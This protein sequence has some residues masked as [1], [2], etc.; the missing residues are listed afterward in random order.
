MP[1]REANGDSTPG[2]ALERMPSL[3][4]RNRLFGKHSQELLER[5]YDIFE[6]LHKA[7]LKIQTKKCKLFR[8]ETEF[9]GHIIKVN[10]EKI[11]AIEDWPVPECVTELR[12]LFGTASYCRNFIT[13]FATVAAMLQKLTGDGQTFQ[14]TEASQE[15]FVQLTTA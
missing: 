10:T 1:V 8:Q 12:S 7:G 2:T 13:K 6:R 3:P 4:R 9:L 11:S 5:M 14:W 15:A